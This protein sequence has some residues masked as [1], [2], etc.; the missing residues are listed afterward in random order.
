MMTTNLNG[1][2][3]GPG[4]IEPSKPHAHMPMG[5]G[6]GSAEFGEHLRRHKHLQQHNKHHHTLLS[7][8][9]ESAGKRF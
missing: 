3:T 2:H 4:S 8:K 6:A 1:I 9:D 7:S 5:T